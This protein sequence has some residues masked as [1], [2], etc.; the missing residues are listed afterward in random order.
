MLKNYLKIAWRNLVKNRAHTFINVAGLTVGMAVAILIGLWLHDELTFNKHYDNYDR[1]AQVMQNQSNNGEVQTMPNEPWP[2]AQELRKSYGSDFK[3]VTMTTGAG[4]HTL[5]WGEK[6]LSQQGVYF[7]PQALDM[8]SIKMLRG[9]RNVFDD[10]N[11]IILSAS[12]AKAYFG[13]EG[14]VNKIMKLD[15]RTV[16]KVTGVYEDQPYNTKFADAS[17][18]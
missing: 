17:F 6:V 18:F 11:S 4:M 9:G 13:N 15:D 10:P 1:I 8:F 14:P 12:L 2:L 7:E 16:V 3:Y 5:V